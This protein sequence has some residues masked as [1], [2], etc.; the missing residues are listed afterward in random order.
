MT[1]Y[2]FVKPTRLGCKIPAHHYG[3]KYYTISLLLSSG[4][5][6]FYCS[7][8]ETLIFVALIKYKNIYI[9][10]EIVLFVAPEPESCL[11]LTFK[12]KCSDAASLPHTGRLLSPI[13]CISQVK[14]GLSFICMIAFSKHAE[15]ILHRKNLHL[16][17]AIPLIHL[18]LRKLY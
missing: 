17:F 18:R 16:S 13:N 1:D 8:L 4:L 10:M 6:D 5:P 12:K 2:F 15:K 3:S 9:I 7:D 14:K 11:L